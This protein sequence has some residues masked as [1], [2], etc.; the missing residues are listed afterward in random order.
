MLIRLPGSCAQIVENLLAG[1]PPPH[2]T[3]L[4]NFV[5][6]VGNPNRQLRQ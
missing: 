5:D 1:S 4:L 3:A 2:L 6:Q